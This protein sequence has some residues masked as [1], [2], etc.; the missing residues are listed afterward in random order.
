MRKF[1][2]KS[3]NILINML[4]SLIL[5]VTLLLTFTTSFYMKK[6]SN[7]KINSSTVIKTNKNIIRSEKIDEYINNIDADKYVED[8]NI[9]KEITS[10]LMIEDNKY[11]AKIFDYKTGK[12]LTLDTIIKKDQIDNFWR[13]ISEL[14]YLKYPKFIADV[15]SLN[16]QENVYYLKDNELIIYYYNYTIEPAVN[17]DLFLHVNYNEIKEY[18]DITVDLDSDYHNEDGFN[19]NKGKKLVAITFDD[20]PGPYTDYLV[21]TLNN[22]KAHATFF[23]LGKN[24]NVYKNSVVNVYNSGNEIGYHSYAHDNFKRQELSTIKSEYDLSNEYLKSIIGTT[25][26]LTRPPYGSLNEDI[27]NTLNT[28]FILWNID[29]EDW[30]HKDV[31]YLTQYVL[32][33]IKEGSIILFHDIHKTSVQTMEKLLPK[34]YALGYQVVTVSTLAEH[35]GIA[36]EPHQSYRYFK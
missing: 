22:N 10:V 29:T 14:L 6:L 5:I 23:M 24:I 16:N 20:G 35:Y 3:N 30:R 19:I 36:L 26:A 9:K 17:E 33:N 15:L 2:F 7:E 13:K 18:L 8:I 31:E 4:F 34:L 1:K 28:P 25:F 21:D 32:D 12:E 11:K 27:K